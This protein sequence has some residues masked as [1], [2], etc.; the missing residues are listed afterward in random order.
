M[1]RITSKIAALAAV[2]ML[3]LTAASTAHAEGSA[4]T[5]DRAAG[6][7]AYFDLRD[8]TG[9]DFVVKLTDPQRVQ[10]AR[11]IVRTGEPKIVIGRIV[12][13]TAPY[14]PRWSFYL[15]PDTVTFADAAI[16]VCDAS[17]PYVEDHLDEA[18]GAFL[19]GLYWCPWSGR[20]TREI[21]AP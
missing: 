12:K 1:R 10:E 8:N 9:S 7:A 6:D 4:P 11:D 17:T 19:P 15:D 13:R 21:P 3:S 5:R 14:N 2:A 18:G 20:L 16:E